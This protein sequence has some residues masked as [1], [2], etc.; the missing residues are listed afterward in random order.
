MI[1]TRFLLGAIIVL[2][3]IYY[4]MIIGHLFNKWKITERE[5]EFYKLC[6]PFYYWVVSQAI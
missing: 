5:I 3:I 2:L 4:V 1:Y 6:I